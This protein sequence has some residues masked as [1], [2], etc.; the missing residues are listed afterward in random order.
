MGNRTNFQGTQKS[1]LLGFDPEYK[2]TYHRGIHMDWYIDPSLF[3]E[4]VLAD[5][6]YQPQ[7]GK[8]VYPHM[9]WA[10]I[11]AEHASDLMRAVIRSNDLELDLMTL[12]DIYSSQACDSNVNRKRLMEDGIA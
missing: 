4:G 11:F 5:K 9:R 1:V 8:S 10:K 6:R 3:K 12:V 7:S 2:T